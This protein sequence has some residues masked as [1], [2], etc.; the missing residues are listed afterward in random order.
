[1]ISMSFTPKIQNKSILIVG[2]VATA[3]WGVIWA[4]IAQKIPKTTYIFLMPALTA[5]AM[6]A[7]TLRREALIAKRARTEK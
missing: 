2:V 7:V 6:L 5:T 4:C 3:I 1:M